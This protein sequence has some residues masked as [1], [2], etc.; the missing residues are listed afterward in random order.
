M[1]KLIL[2]A[3]T[4]IALCL[5]AQAQT[6]TSPKLLGFLT[7]LGS[8]LAKATNWTV[9]PYLTYA[10]DAPRK[11]G[12]GLLAVYDVTEN[13]GVGSG[14]DWLGSFN[15]ISGNVTLKVPLHPL[16][17]LG[18]NWTNVVMTPIGIAGLGTPVG[19]AD[20]DNGNLSTI[21][22]AGMGVK[23]K[24][25]KGWDIGGGYAWTHWSGAGDFSG[26]HHQIFVQ[27]SKGI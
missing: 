7:D 5:P 13:I 25:W 1:K 6:N 21:A 8:G 27:L 10:P 16:E 24:R 26:K 12:G 11:Y 23:L 3:L 19:G 22:G 15:L 4:A 17:K 14:I 2:S 20:A 18:G 9:A